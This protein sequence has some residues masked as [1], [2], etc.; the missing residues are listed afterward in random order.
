MKT[1]IIL[2]LLLFQVYAIAQDAN[3]EIE[4]GI[5]LLKKQDWEGAIDIFLSVIDDDEN[6]AEAHYHAAY[7]YYRLGELDEAIE[8]AE[9]SVE[10]ED[11][12]AKY[13]F[14]LGELYGI[15]A[16]EA[17]IFRAPGLAGDIKEQFERVVELDPSHVGGQMALA[18]FYFQAPGIVGGDIDKAIEHAKIA[19]ALDEKQGRLLLGQIYESEERVDEAENEFQYLE[20]NFGNDPEFYYLY[21]IYGYFLMNQDR[22]DEAI[23]KF[24]KQIDLAPDRYYPY[25]SL[26]EA[27]RK[28]GMLKEALAEYKK[29]VEINPD[30][31]SALNAIEEIEDE[32]E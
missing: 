20:Q 10:L 17:S 12:S 21:N 28:K 4:N 7:T 26:G 2:S 31:E 13:H 24:K 18:Q 25:N 27:Y 14:R 23:E 22:V 16:M 19:A 5:N 32:L 6:N 11:D 8:Y 9:R 30:F 3:A 15:D 1:L 29:A